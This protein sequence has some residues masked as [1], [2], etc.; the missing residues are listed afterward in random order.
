M[1]KSP[2]VEAIPVATINDGMA[3]DDHDFLGLDFAEES[4]TTD[5]QSSG[6]PSVLTI[7]MLRK[8]THSDVEAKRSSRPSS[9]K[10]AKL[11]V[12]MRNRM[13]AETTRSAE[14]F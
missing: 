6:G 13:A 9:S 7:D 4:S 10:R 1:Q 12:A 5:R 2:T 11:S 8:R 3:L 14:L